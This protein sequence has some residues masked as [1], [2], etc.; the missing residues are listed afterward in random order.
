MVR[1]IVVIAKDNGE[2][3]GVLKDDCFGVA[4]IPLRPGDPETGLAVGVEVVDKPNHVVPEFS[5]H[6]VTGQNRAQEIGRVSL[7]GRKRK[8]DEMR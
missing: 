3:L 4:R 8:G 5:R 7:G 6:D 2:K 1:A